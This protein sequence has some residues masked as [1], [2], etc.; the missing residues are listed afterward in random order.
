MNLNELAALGIDIDKHVR[1][2]GRYNKS[3]PWKHGKLY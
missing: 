1:L 3:R 2:K